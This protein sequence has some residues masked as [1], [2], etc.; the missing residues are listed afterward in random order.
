MTDVVQQLDQALE[1]A[2]AGLKS[3]VKP[4][5]DSIMSGSH[6]IEPEHI[7]LLVREACHSIS[8]VAKSHNQNAKAGFARNDIAKVKQSLRAA[9]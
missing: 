7:G 2:E 8:E 1:L 3:E 6:T 5:L 4:L 9:P